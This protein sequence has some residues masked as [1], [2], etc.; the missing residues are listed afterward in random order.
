MRRRLAAFV[1]IGLGAALPGA[2][3][4]LAAGARGIALVIQLGEGRDSIIDLCVAEPAGV[5]GAQ[6]LADGLRQAGLAAPTYATSGLLC[7]IA[8][9][10]ATGCGVRTAA[11]YQYW[12]YFHGSASGWTY[13]AD[14]PGTHLASPDSAEGWRFEGAG[15]GHPNDPGPVV[16]ADPVAVCAAA[17]PVPP[18]TAPVPTTSAPPVVDHTGGVA[19]TTTAATTTTTVHPGVMTTVGEVSARQHPRVAAAHDAVAPGSSSSWGALSGVALLCVVLGA[20]IV[21]WR[22]RAT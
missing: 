6:A 13:A 11:G 14:G 2:T 10:P 1:A 17:H 7:S 3:P 4:A 9:R 15:S 20:G 19:T 5:S 12:A 16:A 21:I 8:G 22:R 18:T